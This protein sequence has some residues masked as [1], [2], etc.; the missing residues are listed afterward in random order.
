MVGMCVRYEPTGLPAAM[1]DGQA[2]A[3]YGK[4]TIVMKN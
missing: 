2:S 1:I 3:G 4:T